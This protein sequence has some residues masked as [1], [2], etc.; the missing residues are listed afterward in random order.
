M[1]PLTTLEDLEAAAAASVASVGNMTGFVKVV[2]T[3]VKAVEAAQGNWKTGVV[4]YAFI[5]LALLLSIIADQHIGFGRVEWMFFLLAA[6]VLLRD[7]ARAG[8]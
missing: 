7:I 6:L 8:F 2:A 1:S 5:V 4:S 3:D